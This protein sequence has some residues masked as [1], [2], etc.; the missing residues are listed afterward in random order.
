[1]T[2]GGCLHVVVSPVLLALFYACAVV[3]IGLIMQ[4]FGKDPLRLK[5]NSQTYWVERNPPGPEPE[6]MAELF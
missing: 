4:L 3:P 5:K 6:S 1:M 2:L